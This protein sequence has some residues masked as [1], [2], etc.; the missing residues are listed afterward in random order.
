MAIIVDIILKTA[1]MYY[2]DG[3]IESGEFR[4]GRLNG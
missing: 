1:T 2:S 3:Y 4:E